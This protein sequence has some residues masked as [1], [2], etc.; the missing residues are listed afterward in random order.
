M[1]R[2][3]VFN[4]KD[5]MFDIEGI[6][7]EKEIKAVSEDIISGEAL[8]NKLQALSVNDLIK[9]EMDKYRASHPHLDYLSAKEWALSP[10]G[11]EYIGNILAMHQEKLKSKFDIYAD[12]RL[13]II[14]DDK[15]SMN[16]LSTL[17][18]NCIYTFEVK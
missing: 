7:H 9:A 12:Y 5:N 18:H 16:E 6:L 8:V 13:S 15:L 11:K 10:E 4:S 2:V 17:L 14:D 3:L 1:E